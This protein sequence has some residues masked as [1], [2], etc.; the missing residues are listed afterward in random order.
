MKSIKLPREL[1]C[2]FG[3][4]K[5]LVSLVN[6]KARFI[7][8]FLMF[9]VQNFLKGK[10]KKGNQNRTLQFF[11]TVFTNGANFLKIYTRLLFA[12]NLPA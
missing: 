8:L 10:L 5:I 9:S 12:L 4:T 11:R 7:G 6:L 2:N 3:M 1:S